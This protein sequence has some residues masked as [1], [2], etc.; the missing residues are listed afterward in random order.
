MSFTFI[1]TQLMV[2]HISLHKTNSKYF[3]PKYKWLIKCK[4]PVHDYIQ[5]SKLLILIL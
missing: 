4:L 2:D 1:N 3:E 5:N